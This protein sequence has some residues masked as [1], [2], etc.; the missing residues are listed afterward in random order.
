MDAARRGPGAGRAAE[1]RTGAL[2][3][4]EEAESG[5]V[6][7]RRRGLL[8]RQGRGRDRSRRVVPYPGRGLEPARRGAGRGV[9]PRRARR[10]RTRRP[11]AAARRLLPGHGGGAES[12][13]RRRRHH[14]SAVRL[15][16]TA[17][18]GP[19]AR[20]DSLSR[21][22]EGESA[23]RGAGGGKRTAARGR[24]RRPVVL[25]RRRR[26]GRGTD[27]LHREAS[28]AGGAAFGGGRRERASVRG[29]VAGPRAAA[30][31]AARGLPGRAGGGPGGAWP[32]H[33]LPGGGRRRRG[34]QGRVARGPR[35]AV[36]RL[37]ARH[38]GQAGLA[39]HG[40]RIRRLRRAAATTED[41]SGASAPVRAH[42][43][44][45]G[46]VRC[47]ERRGW[48]L[49]RPG[50]DRGSAAGRSS[51]RPGRLREP[52]GGA[53]SARFHRDRP[54]PAERG[55]VAR[56]VDRRDGPPHPAVQQR[57]A[58]R[59]RPVQEG[60]GG[61]GGEPDA[62]G[63]DRGAAAPD[64]GGTKAARDRGRRRDR[65]GYRGRAAGTP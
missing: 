34:R 58:D 13:R 22:P 20:P 16:A 32:V 46:P 63:R 57:R 55:R 27:R 12:G 3:Q 48:R 14:L 2:H 9:V 28:H 26:A 5:S 25:R 47:A 8:S 15:G 45:A 4:P 44:D 23:R 49:H 65:I 37:R 61:P 30:G 51:G 53:L 60:A 43:R 42:A 6:A 33:R 38:A 29:G 18:A 41:R 64:A 36:P 11:S 17:A 50:R 39:A 31:Y 59:G 35:A 56:R 54:V 24:G 19:A 52:D 21:A 7:G 1:P 62:G 10:E 40:R